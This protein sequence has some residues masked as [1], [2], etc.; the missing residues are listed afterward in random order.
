MTITKVSDLLTSSDTA[1]LGLS[2]IFPMYQVGNSSTLLG[3]SAVQVGDKIY[4]RSGVYTAPANVDPSVLDMD[5]LKLYNTEQVNSQI[6]SDGTI[7][8]IVSNGGSTLVATGTGKISYSTDNGITWSAA[9]NVGHVQNVYTYGVWTGA[10]FVI[11]TS[12][13]T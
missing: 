5:H 10:R 7:W 3:K 8:N 2:T 13:N 6:M 9:V 4:L 11:T 1:D 12:G